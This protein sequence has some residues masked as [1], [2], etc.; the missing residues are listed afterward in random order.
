MQSVMQM[1]LSGPDPSTRANAAVY[2]GEH[3]D[4]DPQARETLEQIA[5]SDTNVRVRKAAA[6]ALHQIE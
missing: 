5:R 6:E 3:I 4:E 2:L 1:G